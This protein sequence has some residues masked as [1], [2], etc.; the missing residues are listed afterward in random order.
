MIPMDQLADFRAFC[1][2]CNCTFRPKI[3][4]G[5]VIYVCPNC[6]NSERE[7]MQMLQD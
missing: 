3:Q 4:G 1:F 7:R 2:E 6:R 5:I